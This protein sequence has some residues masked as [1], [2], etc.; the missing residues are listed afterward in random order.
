MSRAR[1]P[2]K[3]QLAQGNKNWPFPEEVLRGEKLEREAKRVAKN[4]KSNPWPAPDESP[5]VTVCKLYAGDIETSDFEFRKMVRN[6][7]KNLS[8]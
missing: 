5:L 3:A 7:L 4:A 6:C 8:K 1:K 2:T